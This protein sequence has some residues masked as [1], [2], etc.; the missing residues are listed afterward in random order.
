[1]N[2]WGLNNNIF[3]Y[4]E[5][6]M[7][8]FFKKNKDNLNFC[9]FLIPTSI[10]KRIEEKKLRVKVLNTNEKWYGITY[11]EDKQDLVNAISKMIEEGKYP[12]N[13]WN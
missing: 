3:G 5:E 2:M 7:N 11:K 4:L 6:E 9:E 10:F 1:M 8:E 13:L 12:K